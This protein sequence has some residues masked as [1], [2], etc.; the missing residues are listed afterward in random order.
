MLVLYILANVIFIFA[1]SIKNT[2]RNDALECAIQWTVNLKQRQWKY[3]KSGKVL[4]GETETQRL[5][6]SFASIIKRRFNFRG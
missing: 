6:F 4:V 5:F 2:T 3:S 1:F